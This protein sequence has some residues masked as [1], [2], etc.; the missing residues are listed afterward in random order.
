MYEFMCRVSSQR[1]EQDD[2]NLINQIMNEGGLCILP[3][4]SSYILTGLLYKTG[5]TKDLDILLERKG[6]KMSLAFGSLNQANEMMDLSDMAI[7]FFR[8]FT[9]GGLTFVAKPRQKRSKLFSERRLHADGTIGIRLTESEVE[10]QLAENYPLPSTPIRNSNSKEVITAE[11]ALQIIKGRMIDKEIDRKIALVNGIVPYPSRL[12]TVVKEEFHDGVW[13][14]RIIR[15]NAIPF[16]RIRE[17][18]YACGYADT[19]ID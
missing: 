9:P 11:E 16:E 3:S 17:V 13:Q 18:A 19:I 14:L 10:T 5:V 8:K 4:D 6:M 12:S 1:L 15:E 7:D 2:V